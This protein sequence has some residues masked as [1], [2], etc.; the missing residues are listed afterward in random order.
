[1]WPFSIFSCFWMALF[2][3]LIYN[4]IN[5]DFLLN[6]VGSKVVKYKYTLKYN[7]MMTKMQ[8]QEVKWESVSYSVVWLWF[9]QLYPTLSDPTYCN[10][11]PWNSPDK[12]T[13]VGNHFLLP[14]IFPTQGQN[15]GLLHSRQILYWLSHQGSPY[16]YTYKYFSSHSAFFHFCIFCSLSLQRKWFRE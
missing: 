11:C 14:G 1:M 12:N 2:I 3:S 5:I 10:L 13:G 7:Q 6:S 8:K 4:F 9:C 16:I 15:W